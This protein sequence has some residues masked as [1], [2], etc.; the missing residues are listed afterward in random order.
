M[1]KIGFIYQC[2]NQDL[3]LFRC[4]ESV[5]KYYKTEPIYLMCDNGNDYS[6]VAKH[7]KCKYVHY[8][9]KAPL[10]LNMGNVDKETI[11]ERYNTY[12]TRMRDACIFLKK[13]DYVVRLEDDV[14]CVGRI[15]HI[16]NFDVIGSFNVYATFDPKTNSRINFI[17]GTP[18]TRVS[19]KIYIFNC[20][21]GSMFKTN[22][23][24][25]YC[26]SMLSYPRLTEIFYELNNE[27]YVTVD[28]SDGLGMLVMGYT[29]GR[30]INIYEHIKYDESMTDIAIYHPDKSDYDKECDLND[31]I[32][33]SLYNI[34]GTN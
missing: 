19:D 14:R 25:D 16:P 30:S 17:R 15:G 5:R 31:L 1:K 28:R 29:V 8:K 2:Y 33:N 3:S 21:G 24:T 23:F 4:L 11:L 20:G 26:N 6:E 10:H 12:L 7:F 18:I 22:S 13:C 34:N 9:D 32:K 27:N